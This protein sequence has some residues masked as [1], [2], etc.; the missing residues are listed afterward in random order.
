M[1]ILAYKTELFDPGWYTSNVLT[2]SIS[3]RLLHAIPDLSI[4]PKA[5]ITNEPHTAGVVPD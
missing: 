4:L 2:S 1:F 3:Q 5:S